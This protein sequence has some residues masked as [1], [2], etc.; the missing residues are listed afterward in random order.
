M[1]AKHRF[2]PPSKEAPNLRPKAV[3]SL[4][5]DAGRKAMADAYIHAA[6]I[7]ACIA[8]L[9]VWLMHSDLR[10]CPSPPATI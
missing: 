8:S 7:V 3:R 4:S 6:Y 2:K 1:L 9:A 10:E 5:Y